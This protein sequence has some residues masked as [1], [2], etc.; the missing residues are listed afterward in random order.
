MEN[1]QRQLVVALRQVVR[2]FVKASKDDC[3][4]LEPDD[5]IA[6]KEMYL[7]D[8]QD[9]RDIANLIKDGNL[10]EAVEKQHHL[11]TMP[12]SAIHYQGELY[13]PILLAY[14]E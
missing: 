2:E 10:E 5:A 13:T 11:D 14:F 6:A 8:A 12:R 1:E 9:Y 7:G 3:E 4:G